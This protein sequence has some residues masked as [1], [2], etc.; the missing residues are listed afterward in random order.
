MSQELE[1]MANEIVVTIADNMIKP[2]TFKTVAKT[3]G[4]LKIELTKRNIDFE[5]KVFR[6]GMTVTELLNDETVLPRMKG[7]RPLTELFIMMTAAKKNI[8]S[9]NM[10]RMELVSACS[11]LVKKNPALK[12]VFGNISTTKSVVLEELYEKHSNTKAVATTQPAS[13]TSAKPTVTSEVIDNEW[14]KEFGIKCLEGV[15]EAIRTVPLDVYVEAIKS[16]FS[17]EDLAK[18]VQL[19]N[20]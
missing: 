14:V 11:A 15:I 20:K 6:E 10:T 13:I 5:N 18:M 7:D 2:V 12:D 1:L 3:L 16:S 19:L 17:E 4:E 8:S 9:G